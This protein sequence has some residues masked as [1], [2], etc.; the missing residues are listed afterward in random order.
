MSRLI[1]V[2]QLLLAAILAMF[3]LFSLA[4]IL[5]IASRQETISVVNAF[6]GLGVLVVCLA[7]LARILLKKGLANW[8]Q[9]PGSTAADAVNKPDD[10]RSG[11]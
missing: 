11:N 1:A 4:N 6:I 2:G 5:F 10:S 3:A 8:R 9:F 7:A